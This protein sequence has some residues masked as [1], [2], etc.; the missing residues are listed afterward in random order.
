MQSLRHGPH[1]AAWPGSHSHFVFAG[2]EDGGGYVVRG[3]AGFFEANSFGRHATTSHVH[4]GDTRVLLGLS[5][6][7]GL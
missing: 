7:F 1:S 3:F 4:K 5:A 6:F 2:H